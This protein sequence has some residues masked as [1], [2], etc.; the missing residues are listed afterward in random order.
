MVKVLIVCVHNSARSQ[1]SMTFLNDY[2]KD[3]FIAESAGL[4]KGTLNP[5]LFISRSFKNDTLY[6]SR[7]F[8]PKMVCTVFKKAEIN[9]H[10]TPLS[11]RH[12]AT[13]FN[14][15]IGNSLEET[16]ALMCHAKLDITHLYA[17]HL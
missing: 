12:S 17:H 15:K 6:L 8:M 13:T 10:F 4:E 7:F 16:K 5:Y 3:L 1:M 2:G 14:L 9:R 11:I